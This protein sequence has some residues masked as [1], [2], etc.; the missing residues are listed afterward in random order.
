MRQAQND[1]LEMAHTFDQAISRSTSFISYLLL[2]SGPRLFISIASIDFSSKV[3]V[4]F[5]CGTTTLN[6]GALSFVCRKVRC[7]EK[8]PDG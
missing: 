5:R 8:F 7:L 4:K 3:P 2:I 1:Q 6:F